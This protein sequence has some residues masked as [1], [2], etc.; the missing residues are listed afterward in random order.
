MFDALKNQELW[1][2]YVNSDTTE[3][4]GFNYI[5]FYCELE[6]TALRLCKG[7]DVQG[8]DGTV[9]K[10]SFPVINNQI[11]VPLLK[12]EKPRYPD[13]AEQEKLNKIK[14]ISEKAKKLGLSD[15]DIKILKGI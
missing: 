14:I 12:I 5:K 10:E 4:R 2:V 3:G 1:V 15:T 6:S 8:T 11:Y 9:R 7:Q 13:E